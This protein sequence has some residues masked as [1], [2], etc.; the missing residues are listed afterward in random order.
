MTEDKSALISLFLFFIFHFVYRNLY[1]SM[2]AEKVYL[3]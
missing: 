2:S 3:M 1:K